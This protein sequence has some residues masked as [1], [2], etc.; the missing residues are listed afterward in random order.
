MLLSGCY[1]TLS[2]DLCLQLGWSSSGISSALVMASLRAMVLGF[3][4]FGIMCCYAL[5][6]NKKNVSFPAFPHVRYSFPVA[7]ELPLCAP[8]VVMRIC[9]LSWGCHAIVV[10]LLSCSLFPALLIWFCK[11]LFIKDFAVKR[12]SMGFAR[13]PSKWTWFLWNQMHQTKVRIM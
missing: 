8:S 10:V 3:S 7:I 12:I 1:S 9:Q 11:N 2:L 4:H 5:T 6:S 13:F